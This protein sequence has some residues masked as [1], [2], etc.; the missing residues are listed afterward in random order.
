MEMAASNTTAAASYRAFRHPSLS[1]VHRVLKGAS[2]AKVNPR[3]QEA[4][5]ATPVVSSAVGDAS[6]MPLTANEG[7]NDDRLVTVCAGDGDDACTLGHVV[8]RSWNPSSSTLVAAVIAG[9]ATLPGITEGATVLHLGAGAD[10]GYTSGFLSDLVGPSGTVVVVDSSTEKAEALAAIARG[11]ENVVA[12]SEDARRPEAYSAS[13]P[14][15]M[16]DCIVVGLRHADQA[17]ML[18]VNADVFLRAGGG[19]VYVVDAAAMASDDEGGNAA[20]FKTYADH[21]AA[22]KGLGLKPREQI[23]LEPY[24]ERHAVITLVKPAPK[25]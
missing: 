22:L 18:E 21:V 13:I 9:I 14:K 2:N 16:V 5:V 10:G 4:F 23:T 19:V 6:N 17:R 25:D 3:S 8:L 11:R 15:G 24:F 12:V 1:R 20:C 7:D